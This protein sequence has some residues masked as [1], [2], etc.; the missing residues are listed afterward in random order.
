M[1]G[2]VPTLYALALMHSPETSLWRL[3][4]LKMREKILLKTNFLDE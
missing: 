1:K 4:N 3:K 2:E